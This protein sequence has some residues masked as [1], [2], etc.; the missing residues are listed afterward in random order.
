MKR[1]F[2]GALDST[3]QMPEC[4]AILMSIRRITR[5]VDRHSKQLART[6]GLSVPQLLVMHAIRRRGSVAIGLIAKDVCQSQATITTI[7]DRLESLGLL[8]RDRSTDD[9]RIVHVNLT[10]A[11]EQK[12]GE[13]PDLIQENFVRAFGEL[14]RWEQQMILSTLDRV[15]KMLNPE[16]INSPTAVVAGGQGLSLKQ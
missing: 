13:S 9:R 12:L 14:D 1:R 8:H 15:A 3:M 4:D 2:I 7:I 5:A 6:S 16:D 10:D 11:G